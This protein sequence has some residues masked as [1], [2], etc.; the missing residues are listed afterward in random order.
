[1]YILLG[2]VM[3]VYLTFIN[4]ST[5]KL[6][7]MGNLIK[8]HSRNKDHAKIQKLRYR[9]SSLNNSDQEHNDSD[10]Q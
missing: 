8:S 5:Q 1:M 4:N 2:N 7:S 10:H 9:I 3:P 6:L